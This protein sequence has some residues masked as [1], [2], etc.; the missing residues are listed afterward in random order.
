MRD[1]R[2]RSATPASDVPANAVPPWDALI[3]ESRV[4]REVVHRL[5]R[6]AAGDTTL[7]LEGES[8]TGK[9]LA[10]QAVHASSARRHGPFVV[11]DC[12]ANPRRFADES[13]FESARGGTI[14]LDEIGELDLALQPRLLRL[15]ENR[16]VTLLGDRM[17]PGIDVRVIA[18]TARDLSREAAQGNFRLDLY[19]RLAVNCVRLPSLSQRADDIPLLWRHFCRELGAV[20]LEHVLDENTARVLMSRPWPGNVRE[21]RNTVERVATFGAEGLNT[22]ALDL[23]LQ[24]VT[25]GRRSVASAGSSAAPI[26]VPLPPMPTPPAG[27]ATSFHT[28]KASLLA[29]FERDFLTRILAQ[30]DGNITAAAAAAGLDR[31]HFL[32]LLDRYGL[33]KPRA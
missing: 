7:L 15:V 23:P 25:A 24:T 9:E 13:V 4:M 6:I 22:P 11:V 12:R 21:L 29:S 19:Y 27:E 32:R 33:R 2:I 1:L 18:A 28:A 31:V 14:F 26:P 16:R 30:H 10:A 5:R 20:T 8:G 3:G 17:T